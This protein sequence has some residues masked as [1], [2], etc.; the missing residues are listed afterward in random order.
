MVKAQMKIQQTAFMLIALTIFFVLV[1]LF[2]LSI[3]V[4][5]LKQEAESLKEETARNLLGKIANSPEFSCGTSFGDQMT[6][7]VDFDKLLILKS[8]SAEYKNFWGL[9]QLEVIRL[10]PSL[11]GECFSGNY[12]DCKTLSLFQDSEEGIYLETFISLCRRDSYQE[13]PY[14]KCEVA[15]MLIS[16]ETIN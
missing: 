9:S 13:E 16:Y 1:A 4:A 12:P 10:D 6:N 14:D 3:R 2:V 8:K 11:Q 7:C 15:K 5:N